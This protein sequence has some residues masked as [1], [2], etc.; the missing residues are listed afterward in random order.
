MPT[1]PQMCVSGA[2]LLHLLLY[3]SWDHC[4]P[5]IHPGVRRWDHLLLLSAYWKYHHDI[6][7]CLFPKGQSSQFESSQMEEE[8]IPVMLLKALIFFYCPVYF[9][10]NVFQSSISF[11][12]KPKPDLLPLYNHKSTVNRTMIW[13]ETCHC[14]GR[15]QR[16]SGG[17][18]PPRHRAHSSPWAWQRGQGAAPR[19]L[20]PA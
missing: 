12:T 16:C 10:F 15:A 2:I 17:C 13:D 7:S 6:I 20:Q 9:T 11:K 18:A 19:T 3:L 8:R 4:R 5:S 14:S 1:K